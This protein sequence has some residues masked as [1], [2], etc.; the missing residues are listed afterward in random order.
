MLR[1]PGLLLACAAAHASKPEGATSLQQPAEPA[2]AEELRLIDTT[3]HIGGMPFRILGYAPEGEG[4]PVYVFIGGSLTPTRLDAPEF[5]F[6]RD[7]ASRGFVSV[8]V[9]VPGQDLQVFPEMYE[10]GDA[11]K[12]RCAGAPHSLLNASRAVFQHRSDTS[13]TSALA[14]IC[15]LPH[16]DCDA[17]IAL[18]GISLGGLLTTVAPTFATGITGLLVWSAGVFV[19]GGDSCCGKF[20]GN[21]SCC[22]DDADVV[23]GGEL[24][25]CEGYDA[26]STYLDRT[27]RRRVIAASDYYYGDCNCP[28]DSTN[29]DDCVCD[30]HGGHGALVQ[31]SL[32]SGYECGE[33][34]DCIQPDGSGYYV[35]SREEVAATESHSHQGH[36]FWTVAPEYDRLN[37]AFVETAAAWGL[38]SGFDWLAETARRPLR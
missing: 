35:P 8:M 31:S 36:V 20:S 7:M 34:R 14:T 27:R 32:T 5:R 12:M 28:P 16:A 23:V 17:G 15:S 22:G 38:Q 11:I 21:V 1:W 29:F 10:A 18:H 13:G 4:L 9:E 37:P 2:T 3:Y 33:R 24:M 6:T 30:S 25:F 19:G 26:T